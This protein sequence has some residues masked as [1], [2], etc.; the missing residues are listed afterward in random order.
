MAERG[1]DLEGR[2]TL[3][4][5]QESDMVSFDQKTAQNIFDTGTYDCGICLDPKKGTDCMLS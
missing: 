4:D 1:F 5:A 3:S 2:L